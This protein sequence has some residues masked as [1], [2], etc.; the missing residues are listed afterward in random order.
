[1]FSLSNSLTGVGGSIV[2]CTIGLT[3][4]TNIKFKMTPVIGG[5]AILLSLYH[6]LIKC[7]FMGKSKSEEMYS[8]GYYILQMKQNYTDHCTDS[9]IISLAFH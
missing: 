2:S 9:Y 4:T 1:M 6:Q 3:A 5:P 7:T 8:G